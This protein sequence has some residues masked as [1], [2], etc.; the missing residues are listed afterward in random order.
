M[1]RSRW[2]L[3]RI[4]RGDSV[5]SGELRSKH[6]VYSLVS[7]KTEMDKSTG[8]DLLRKLVKRS[9]EVTKFMG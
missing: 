3:K 4:V 1:D 8:W 2:P 7:K 9:L 6:E 5:P